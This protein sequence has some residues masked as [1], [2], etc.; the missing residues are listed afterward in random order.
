MM[1]SSQALAGPLQCTTTARFSLAQASAMATLVLL[2]CCLFITTT[3]YAQGKKVVPDKRL[4]PH[5]VVV[6]VVDSLQ[7][8]D[9]ANDLGIATVFEFASPKNR[10]NTGPLARFTQMIKRGFPDMLNHDGA[11]YDALEISGDTAVQAVWLLTN[12]GAEVGYAFQLGK[13]KSGTYKDMWMTEAVVPLGES[14]RSGT[15]I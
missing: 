9:D 3:T 15:R 13:Q 12:S 8:N 14:S 4:Q 2:A 11:R 1:A 6:I 5:E 7:S 10:A